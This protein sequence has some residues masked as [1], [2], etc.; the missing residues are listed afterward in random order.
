M[1]TIVFSIVIYIVFKIIYYVKYLILS[2]RYLH[3]HLEV[4]FQ[5]IQ[6]YE[7]TVFFL[8]LIKLFLI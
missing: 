8:D 5:I 4:L 6:I 1:N 3:E 7:L 2:I